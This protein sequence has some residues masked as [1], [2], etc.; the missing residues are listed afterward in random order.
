MPG[1]KRIA[2]IG[3]GVMGP[4]IAISFS[5][6]GFPVAL[7]DIDPAALERAE[8]SIHSMACLFNSSP[9]ADKDGGKDIAAGISLTTS[10][11][12]ATTKADFILEA[13]KEELSVK[14]RVFAEL[15][16]V[17]PPHAI[18]ASNSSTLSIDSIAEKVSHKERT[19]L[20]HFVNPPEVMPVVEVARGSATSNK[21]YADTV[22]LIK[23][24]GKNAIICDKVVPGYLVNS[25][26]MAIMAAALDFLGNGV[27]T[28][29]EIDFAF[30]RGLGPRL[31]IMGPFKTMDLI[32]LDLIWQAVLS[33]D[34]NAH[35]DPRA[36]RLRELVQAGH[37]GMKTG[38]GFYDYGG[39]SRDEV[40]QEI[41]R[42]LLEI[43]TNRPAGT[44]GGTHTHGIQ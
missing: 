4:G 27:A 35:S 13:V 24:I 32:G 36:A 22:N 20:T 18:L 9:A 37:F 19:I 12:E 3:A 33:F 8:T 41:D 43:V 39:R 15:E 10:I 5:R 26:N 7:A 16:K 1:T 28:L 2:V 42:Q 29:E 14:S 40:M 17:C 30:T 21:T 44:K 38:R 25:F 11:E 6:H 23:L 34:P 31:S